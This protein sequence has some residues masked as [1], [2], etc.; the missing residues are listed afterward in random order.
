VHTS[1]NRSPK[2]LLVYAAL[3]AVAGACLFATLSLGA[4]VS[5]QARAAVVAHLPTTPATSLHLVRALMAILLASSLLG[6]VCRRIQQPPVI[7]EILA[8]ICLGP[9]VLG[10]IS[11]AAMHWVLPSDV[12][13][14]LGTL[15]NIGVILF[16]FLVGLELD[17]SVL[18]T[19]QRSTLAISHASILVPFVLG[20]VAAIWLY[21]TF[22]TP[23]ASFKVFA[24]FLGVSLSVTAFPVLARILTDNGLSRSPMGTV[25]LTC[26][27]VDDVT[28]WCLLAL[29]VGVA[30]SNAWDAAIT[31]VSS[32]AY[33]GALFWLV[34][35]AV[36]RWARTRDGESN[37]SRM[38]VTGVL[39]ALLA[40]ALSTEYIG[41]HAIFGAFLLGAIIPHDSGVASGMRTRIHDLV[42]ALFLPAF[43]AL[44]G[45]RTQL[46]LV[47]GW[48]QWMVC[49]VI[50]VLACA[51]KFGGGYVAA[52]A[53]GLAK[54]DAASIG[55]L[56]NTRGLME[57]V[58]L[59]IGYDLGVISPALFAMMVVMALVTTF[60]TSPLLRLTHSLP[61]EAEG[62]AVS[63]FGAPPGAETRTG[64]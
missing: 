8:G 27:A 38:A 6:V 52:R 19:N 30:K 24:L 3:I 32:L 45:L 61:A 22:G 64:A 59:D 11:P 34:R 12:P 47:D 48:S 57:L 49:G 26:A 16:M 7:G 28:A 35:P 4:A 51:G 56:M 21:P 39:L 23:T 43:Y 62:E 42:V 20:S 14:Q 37:V 25:A 60:L 58:V 44:T 46:G 50:I 2:A 1:A 36:G 29:V 10:R 17:T 54:R 5:P 18:R 63:V 40:S 33:V 41:I 53:V 13:P 55:V 15:S 31:C 9:S